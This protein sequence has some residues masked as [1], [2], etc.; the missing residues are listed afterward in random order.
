MWSSVAC[1]WRLSVDTVTDDHFPKSN[2]WTRTKLQQSTQKRAIIDWTLFK[3]AEETF[4][5]S[6]QPNTGCHRARTVDHSSLFYFAQRC[7]II[8]RSKLL[9][10][11]RWY[12]RWQLRARRHWQMD[13]KSFN[14]FY[15]VCSFLKKT[16]IESSVW[17]ITFASASNWRQK[18]HNRG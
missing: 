12:H 9:V 8:A 13:T 3:S 14:L 17:Y 11:R 1:R 5:H 18:M 10:W 7:K 15:I 6:K 16:E 2:Y 4:S